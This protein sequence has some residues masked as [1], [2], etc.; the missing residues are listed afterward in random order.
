MHR[1]ALMMF[2]GILVSL[3]FTTSLHAQSSDAQTTMDAL[4]SER[5][6][7]I[8][9]A[10]GWTV[11][12]TEG[13]TQEDVEAIADELQLDVQREI[14][15]MQTLQGWK[16]MEG[17]FLVVSRIRVS[18]AV[19]DLDGVRFYDPLMGVYYGVGDTEVSV[20]CMDIEMFEDDETCSNA[21]LDTLLAHTA[22]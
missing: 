20:S 9:E 11:E 14:L 19:Y 3:C 6:L 10:E 21:V 15:E 7:D 4:T 13:M 2:S 22:P 18:E 16:E 8:L 17:W 12:A 1:L 5:I